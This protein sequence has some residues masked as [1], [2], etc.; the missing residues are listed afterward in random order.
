M[1]AVESVSAETAVVSAKNGRIVVFGDAAGEEKRVY[2]ADG[3]LVYSG[4]DT[5]ISV[6]ARGI[7][8]VRVAGQ[9]FKVA[10]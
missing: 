6:P 4:T 3:R 5:A 7:Y 10:L 9:T 2:G 8:I 1:S